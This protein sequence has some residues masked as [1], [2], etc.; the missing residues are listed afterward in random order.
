MGEFV[1]RQLGHHANLQQASDVNW[2]AR[3]DLISPVVQFLTLRPIDSPKRS[4]KVP[5]VIKYLN[6]LIPVLNVANVFPARS[7]KTVLALIHG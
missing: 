2:A 6:E 3:E 1:F 5:I 7:F 4:N